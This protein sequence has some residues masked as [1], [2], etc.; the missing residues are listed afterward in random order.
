MNLSMDAR[1]GSEVDGVASATLVLEH[2]VMPNPEGGIFLDYAEDGGIINVFD[3]DIAGSFGF[4][5]SR[6][7]WIW[8]SRFGRLSLLQADPAASY[9]LG[10]SNVVVDGSQRDDGLLRLDSRGEVS[11][12]QVVVQ[13]TRYGLYVDEIPESLTIEGLR[14]LRNQRPMKV[15]V[16]ADFTIR[17]SEFRDNRPIEENEPEEPGALWVQAGGAHVV[18]EDSTFA[19]NTG[20]S[21]TSGAV[22]VEAGAEL[23]LRN[24]TFY[25]NSFTVTAASVAARGGAIG[26]R[27][28]A[29]DTVLTL[30]NVTILAPLFTPTGMQGSAL[31]GRG[32]GSDVTLNIFNSVLAGSCRSDGA[33]PD[34]A[35]GNV[36][37]SGDSCGFGSGNLLGVSR[38]DLALGTLGDHG[39]PTA[40]LLPGRWQRRDRCRRRTR[41]PCHRSA[42]PA[43][44]G[45]RRLRCGCSRNQ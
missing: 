34:F 4:Y 28:D 12:Y 29:N 42:R 7:A 24:T 39:G 41:L 10:L 20:T 14:Y 38:A 18:V 9:Q 13:D 22:L 35:V 37:T 17:K 40:T 26:Y 19:D 31:G 45:R 30:Q 5:N 23:T 2:V 32:L 36:K 43:A 27:S 1:G 11:L 3:S 8:D 16:G 25:N 15:V 33:T 44:T 6:I 21:D